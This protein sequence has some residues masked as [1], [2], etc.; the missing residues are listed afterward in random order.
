LVLGVISGV[1]MVVESAMHITNLDFG[2]CSYFCI[3]EFFALVFIAPICCYFIKIIGQ[4]DDRLRNKQIACK[5]QKEQLTKAYNY[6]LSDMDSLLT[7]SAESSAGLAERS[8]ESKRR[9]FQRFLERAQSN[10]S[11]LAASGTVDKDALLTN[12]RSFVG[13][14]LKVFKECSIDPIHNP[15]HILKDEELQACS[16]IESIC[17]LLLPRLRCTEVKFITIR[18]EQDKQQLKKNRKEFRRLTATAIDPN[19]LEGGASSSFESQST[20]RELATQLAPSLSSR[21]RMGWCSFGAFG[22]GC[23]SSRG[24]DGYPKEARCGCFRLILL[25]RAHSSLIFGW[26]FGLLILALEVSRSFRADKEAHLRLR[27]LLE[28]VIVQVCIAVLLIR[29]EELDV[30]QQMEREIRDLKR[31]E[32]EVTQQK[33]KMHEFW[34][35][36]QELTELWLYRTVPRLDLYKEVHE[37]LADA[38]SDKVNVWMEEGNRRLA[39][40]DSNLGDLSNWRNAGNLS[41]EAKKAFGKKINQLCSSQSFEKITDGLD[42]VI[43][44]EIKCLEASAPARY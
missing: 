42:Q 16:N 33:E 25:S 12:F 6:L 31:A 21:R 41:L 8:F 39:L 40:V 4:F 18:Q 14:W 11:Q 5:D 34:S 9:D 17:N 23:S 19:A 2:S 30:V 29:F 27:V 20:R 3:D 1:A 15:K 22:C 44:N 35:S 36:A 13:N 38:P 24:A 28:M 32:Q 26:I 10:F 7:T 37:L 43:A